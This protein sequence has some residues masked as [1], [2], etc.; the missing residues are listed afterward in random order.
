MDLLTLVTLRGIHANV[1]PLSVDH[2]QGLIEAAT[3][4]KLWNIWYASVPTPTNMAKEIEHRLNL[5][6]QG[7]MLPFTVIDNITGQAIGM[8]TYNKIDAVNKRC[9]IGWTWYR[10]SSQRTAI[11]T[12]CKLMLL[13]HAFETLQ[14]IAV[15]ITANEFNLRSR[16]AIERLGAKLDG[17]FRNFKYQNGIVCD[18]YQYSIIDNEWPRIK[19]NLNY[20]LNCNYSLV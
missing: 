11:N 6:K 14:C 20:K 8:T 17:V 10:K 18:Y 7:L 13:T 1:V 3:D 5:H 19:T 4:G 9:D 15:T 2:C 16:R 12:E